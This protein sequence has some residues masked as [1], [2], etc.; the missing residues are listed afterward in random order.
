[1]QQQFMGIAIAL[2][3]ICFSTPFAVAQTIE[4][5][6]TVSSPDSADLAITSTVRA[7][8]LEFRVVPNVRIEFSGTPERTTGW[9]TERQ[10]LP[11]PIQPNV[12]YRDIGIQLQITSVFSDMEIDRIVSEALGEVPLMPQPVEGGLP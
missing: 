5:S 7:R 10:N 1:M 11:K 8:E 6:G 12:T 2:G 4:Q 9:Q 3:W